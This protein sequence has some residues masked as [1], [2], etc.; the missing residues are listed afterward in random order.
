MENESKILDFP[1]D[2]KEWRS[3]GR[4]LPL[5]L[6]KLSCQYSSTNSKAIFS[7]LDGSLYIPDESHTIK[8]AH[9][10]MQLKNI[11]TL[12]DNQTVDELRLEVPLQP[13]NSNWKNKYFTLEQ[14]T[15]SQTC[16]SSV[17]SKVDLSLAILYMRIENPPFVPPPL[18]IPQINIPPMPKIEP[19]PPLFPNSTPN[20]FAIPEIQ[21]ITFP[22][23]NYEP[24]PIYV[25]PPPEISFEN[26]EQQLE[27]S[28]EFSCGFN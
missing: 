8:E 11:K 10:F 2:N 21:P 14:D 9:L 24:T 3:E 19:L 22:Q 16:K 17:N 1:L 27:M 13:S 4:I 23:Y 12:N 5:T 6:L 18:P 20:P 25:P 26:V 28:I 15:K 7:L